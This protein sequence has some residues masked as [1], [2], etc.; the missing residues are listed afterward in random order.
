MFQ[1]KLEPGIALLT[2][3]RTGTWSVD[4]VACYEVALRA[5]L[6]TL[7]SSARPTAFIIDIRSSGVQP[8]DVAEALRHMVARLGPLNAERTAVITSSGLAKLQAG[9]VADKNARVFTSMVLARD[10]VLNTAGAAPDA[11]EGVFDE[12]STAVAVG[13]AVHLHGPSDVD[14][15]LSV[16]AALETATRISDAALDALLASPAAVKAR[17]A[18]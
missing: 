15:T 2:V 12:P 5:E 11:A 13:R 1:F 6:K 16:K 9:R 18:G 14:V 10:W 17:A 8:R 4:T 7:Q 3:T